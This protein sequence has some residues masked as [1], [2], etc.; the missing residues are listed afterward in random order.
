MPQYDVVVEE[1]SHLTYR[2]EADTPQRAVE[3]LESTSDSEERGYPCEDLISHRLLHVN[4]PDT[5]EEVLVGE[6]GETEEFAE[7]I[8][9]MTDESET[10]GGFSCE[11]ACATLNSLIAEARSLT[12]TDPNYPKVFSIGFDDENKDNGKAEAANE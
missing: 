5:G 7:R 6:P 11:D 1:I 9:R 8:A 2:I 10:E 3:I 4:L 12:G